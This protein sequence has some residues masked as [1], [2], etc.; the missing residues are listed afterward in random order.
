MQTNAEIQDASYVHIIKITTGISVFKWTND[1]I[2]IK[3]T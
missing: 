3:V 2:T 1:A